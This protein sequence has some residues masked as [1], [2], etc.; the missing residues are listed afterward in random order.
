MSHRAHAL[1][2]DGNIRG[3]SGGEKRRL[4]IGE[5]LVKD[6]NIFLLDEPTS[7]LDSH[8]AYS[9]IT[10]LRQIAKKQGKIILATLHQPSSRITAQFDRVSLMAQG[11]MVYSGEL[12][13][14]LSFFATKG[15]PCKPMYNPSDHFLDIISDEK[16]ADCFADAYELIDAKRSTTANTNT[17]TSSSL[18]EEK[19]AGSGHRAAAIVSWFEQFKA[20]ALRRFRQWWRD[21]VMLV[22][23]L[24]QYV[25]LGL[26]LGSLF[27][28][29]S[30]NATNGLFDRYSAIFFILGFLC[31]TPMFTVITYFEVE[32]PL[33]RKETATR[34]YTMSAYYLA[35]SMV[36]LLVETVLIL[37]F[38]IITYYL[39]G[40]RPG[41]D[42]FFLFYLVLWLF[43]LISET[44]GL[45]FSAMSPSTTVAIIAATGPIII[46]MA[47]SGF[48]TTST[49]VY[50]EWTTWINFFHYSIVALVDIEMRGQEFMTEDGSTVM[51]ED[52]VRDNLKN[53]L[54]LGANIAVLFAYLIILRF[55]GYL[56]VLPYRNAA[57]QDDDAAAAKDDGANDK[58]KFTDATHSRATSSS[59]VE[60]AG[61]SV[62]AL[63]AMPN[64][65]G[66]MSLVVMEEG[67][68]D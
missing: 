37:I 22:S 10:L 39:T 36:V 44:F 14:T 17:S 43:M 62:V 8:V 28:P 26:F 3:L 35:M 54:S 65:A 63:T 29:L 25:I 51:G 13:E 58:A 52:L 2:G 68:T 46:L 20:L 31:F 15:H 34:M 67:K 41:A 30:Q 48:L 56:L 5:Q 4:S 9:I 40:F 27:R 24:M 18:K 12:K 55:I 49:P 60:T 11:R 53:G 19:I 1:V 59:G 64:R 47:L 7:G 38:A 23:E 6:P 33:L 45:I 50:Y 16:T 57:L 21:P 32:R 61:G 66:A 42:H